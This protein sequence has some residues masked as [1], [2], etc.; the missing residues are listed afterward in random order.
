MKEILIATKNNGKLKEY[1]TLFAPYDLTVRSLFDFPELPEI[2]ETGLTFEENAYIKAKTLH[3][4]TNLPVIADD[5]GLMVDVLNKE[6]GVHSKRYSQEGTDEAN[7]ALLINNLKDYPNAKATFVACIC[8]YENDHNHPIFRGETNG[9]II[10]EGRKGHGFGY[11]PHF[12]LPELNKTMSEL[13]TIEK[14]RVSHRGKAFRLLM[15]YWE[16]NR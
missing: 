14:N 16:N 6:P 2:E 12:Y 4:L 7:N 9:E 13:S 11:D 8:Y 3:Q 15:N 10:H 1:I 5:S